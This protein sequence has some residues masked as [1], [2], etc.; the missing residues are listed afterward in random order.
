MLWEKI[1]NLRL[2]RRSGEIEKWRHLYTVSNFIRWDRSHIQINTKHSTVSH[3]PWK[4]KV[5]YMCVP[6][7]LCNFCLGSNTIQLSTFVDNEPSESTDDTDDINNTN[8]QS[9]LLGKDCNQG[10][11][12]QFDINL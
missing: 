1:I 9:N 6:I 8:D 7:F 5:C 4:W 12:K 11:Y 10:N 3:P 2:K